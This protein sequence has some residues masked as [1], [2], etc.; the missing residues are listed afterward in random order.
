VAQLERVQRLR[1]PTRGD[2]IAGITNALIYLP[3][4]IGYGVVSA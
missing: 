1:P 4:D 3:Q 2:V